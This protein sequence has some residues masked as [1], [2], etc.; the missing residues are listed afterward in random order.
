MDIRRRTQIGAIK[1]TS[2]GEGGSNE[3]PI[4]V[5]N[6]LT[7][8]ARENGLTAS[9]SKNACEYCVDGDGNWKTLS[10]GNRTESINSGHTLSFRGNLIPVSADG[11]GTFTI[12]KKCNLKGNCMSMLF[13]DNAANNYSLSGK[14]YA[15]L[16]LFQNCTN[17]INIS[18]NFLP[19]TTLSGYCYKYMFDGCTNLQNA[20]ILPAL[21]VYGDSYRGMF[22]DCASLQIAPDLP[23][24]SVYSYGYMAMFNGCKSLK[25][26]PY[27]ETLSELLHYV[28]SAMFMNCTNLETGPET[29]GGTS[30]IYGYAC[31]NMFNNCS[32]LKYAPKMPAENF[33]ADAA[34][35]QYDR[36]FYNCSGLIEVRDFALKIAS[37]SSCDGMFG[38]CSSLNYIECKIT[39]F[40]NGTS[41][42]VQNV[43][44]YGTMVIRSEL[45]GQRNNNYI[46]TLWTI[47]RFDPIT[48]PLNL[49]MGKISQKVFNFL[50]NYILSNADDVID[51]IFTVSTV[52]DELKMMFIYDITVYNR[53]IVSLKL[54]TK[55]GI[56]YITFIEEQNNYEFYVNSETLEITCSNSKVL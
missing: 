4:N 13:V 24:T 12:S 38:G 8:E 20:P 51:E 53:L 23:A 16:Q 28:Y 33:N 32:K 5:D 1:K 18:E 49:F 2:S 55:Q 6:Y 39:T 43:A 45:A 19:A 17:L 47:D 52:T 30:Y 3:E 40:N 10:A 37:Y 25:Q 11:I 56:D 48:F 35:H 31:A 9:L 14:S 29:I 7:I 54:Q 46:P 21:T 44:P 27:M 22:Y 42:W 41:N 50:R 34:G 15:F 26:A 36:M